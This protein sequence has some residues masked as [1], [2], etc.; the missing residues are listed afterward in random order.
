MKHTQP[1][2]DQTI[3]RYGLAI[4]YLWIAVLIL[5]DPVGM[6][7]VLQPW[8]LALL[9]DIE[10]MMRSVGIA[11][12]GIGILL[13]LPSKQWYAGLFS[14]G[15]LLTVIA[16][17][18]ITSVTIRNIGLIAMS[19]ALLVDAPIPLWLRPRFARVRSRAKY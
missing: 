7:G 18:G 19:V 15:H 5:R 13:L 14:T 12:I 2:Y 10:G 6:S 11:N 9:P 1:H 16:V 17:T 8:A 4:V 3:L